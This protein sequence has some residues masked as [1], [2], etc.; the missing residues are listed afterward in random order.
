MRDARFICDRPEFM[1]GAA[2]AESAANCCSA[3]QTEANGRKCTESNVMRLSRRLSPVGQATL[4][5]AERIHLADNSKGSTAR[6]APRICRHRR[7]AGVDNARDIMWCGAPEAPEDRLV[8]RGIPWLATE[9]EDV[10][11]PK[12]LDL[13]G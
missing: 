4:G 3:S 9:H 7:A 6:A 2:V 1:V 13:G 8:E 10:L 5:V 11:D 12:T